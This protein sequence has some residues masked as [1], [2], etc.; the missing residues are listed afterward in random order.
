MS[1]KIFD[2]GNVNSMDLSVLKKKGLKENEALPLIQA[3]SIASQFINKISQISSVPDN[4][5]RRHRKVIG[6][7]S[8]NSSVFQKN[9]NLPPGA[10]Q[11]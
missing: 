1:A 2:R 10:L 7:Q 6:N 9:Q 3:Q 4:S 8:I 11:S 5:V